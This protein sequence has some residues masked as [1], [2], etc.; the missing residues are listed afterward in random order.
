MLAIEDHFNIEFPESKL[1]RKTFESLE[2]IA[3]AVSE[4]LACPTPVS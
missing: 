3:E 1:S 4:L 2:S